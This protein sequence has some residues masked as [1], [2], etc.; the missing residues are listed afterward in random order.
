[1]KPTVGRIVHFVDMQ[2]QHCAAIING[3]VDSDTNPVISL[4]VFRPWTSEVYTQTAEYSETP[5]R[6]TWHWPERE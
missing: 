6:Y 3:I 1:M 5:K 4:T 2:E